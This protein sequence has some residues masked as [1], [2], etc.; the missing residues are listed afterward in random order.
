MR[1]HPSGRAPKCLSWRIGPLS[2]LDGV[3]QEGSSAHWR[4][5][6]LELNDCDPAD[7]RKIDAADFNFETSSPSGVGLSI[8]NCTPRR[9]AIGIIGH[10]VSRAQVDVEVTGALEPVRMILESDFGDTEL[11]GSTPNGEE[12]SLEHDTIKRI[13]LV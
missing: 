13:T 8:I 6:R 12:L 2:I 9:A 11:N 7:P 10:F 3:V 5:L 1:S 4:E